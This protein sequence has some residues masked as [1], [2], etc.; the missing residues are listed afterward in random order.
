[1][2]ESLVHQMSGQNIRIE[3]WLSPLRISS[4]K[5]CSLACQLSTAYS[6]LA[7]HSDEQFLAT[8]ITKFPSGKEQGEY[9][10]I[11]L[12]GTNLRIAFVTLLGT[13][14]ESQTRQPEEQN[15]TSV[16]DMNH[17]V[18]SENIQKSYGRSWPIDDHL[19]AENANDLF[20]WVGDCLA[21]V[22]RAR[23]GAA[24]TDELPDEI[25]LG[26]TFSFPMMYVHTSRP[27]FSL[28][29]TGGVS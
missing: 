21:E 11:D 5:L 1:M 14:C 15:G 3:D 4:G 6:H 10:A 12:G 13:S 9:L 8:P 2:P 16:Q 20:T 7:L 18:Y 23:F 28:S 24:N 17:E 25:P 19:K 27:S 22:I 29:R 26:I